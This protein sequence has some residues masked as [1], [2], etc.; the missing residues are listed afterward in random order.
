[1]KLGSGFV[2]SLSW[3]AGGDLVIGVTGSGHKPDRVLVAR[4]GD[5]AAPETVTAGSLPVW[6]D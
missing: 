5:L 4:G 2:D 3:S 6:V 1:V